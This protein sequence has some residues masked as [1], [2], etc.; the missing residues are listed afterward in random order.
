MHWN[1]DQIAALDNRNRALFINALSGFK[2]A[3]LIATCDERR[4]TNLALFS[5]VFHIGSMPPLLGMISRPHSV[6]R[7]T[8]ENILQTGYYT[9]NHVN[10]S[11]I[12]Q[13]HQTS[14]RYDREISEF[15]VTGLNEQWDDEFPVPFVEESR[16]QLGMKLREHQLLEINNTVMII[17]EI[18]CIN[19]KDDVVEQDGYVNI[20]SAGSV[21]ISSLDSYHRTDLVS[22]LSYAKPDRFP[23]QITDRKK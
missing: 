4:T 19:I 17:G 3:N 16:I 6:A 22:H 20:E 23:E 1:T 21:A 18:T 2:S 12:Q 7:H 14:A 9:I 10:E 15:C 5:S 13:S 8:L 11:M